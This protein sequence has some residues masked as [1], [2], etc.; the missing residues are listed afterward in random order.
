[1]LASAREAYGVDRLLFGS[2]AP[3]VAPEVTARFM[4]E[5]GLSD[6]EFMEVLRDNPARLFGD[7]LIASPAHLHIH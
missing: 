1:M 3:A 6:A 5:G 4:R 7:R 2:D